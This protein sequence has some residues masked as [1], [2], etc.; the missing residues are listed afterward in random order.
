LLETVP[1]GNEQQSG[2]LKELADEIE[3]LAGQL[4]LVVRLASHSGLDGASQFARE[5]STHSL[6]LRITSWILTMRANLTPRS[7]FL[8][9]A[10]RL[11][12]CVALGDAVGRMISWQRSYWIP[13]TIAV[14]LKPDFTTTISRGVLRL[15]G[16]FLGLLVA[17]GL[18]HL[19]PQSAVTELFLVG[20]FTLLLRSLGP[21]NYGIF[22][23]AISGLIVFL[24]AETGIPP[25]TVVS[26]RAINT[27]AGGIFALVAYA[28]WPTWERTQV[29]STVADMLD[30]A[31]AYFR[32]VAERFGLSEA[33]KP[34][35]LDQ[36]RADWR[37]TRSAAEAS[38]DR[39]SSEPR[40]PPE[41]S[42][43]LTSMLASSSAFV[44]SVMGLEA[45][46]LKE[47]SHTA[48]EAFRT[49][50]H[51][52]ELTLYFLAAALRGSSGALNVLPKLRED[53][54]RMVQARDQ[55]SLEDELVLIETDRLTSALNTLREQVTRYVGG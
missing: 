44:Y 30:A 25:S 36:Y 20:I 46:I 51:D 35:E 17:T 5:E 38:V 31:R 11:C 55:L 14:V 54:T 42:R 1:Q 19:F 26:E 13:M 37:R 53:Y 45:E 29:S 47:H 48:P 16:T 24:I 18:Y 34:S 21:A 39:V 10:I 32:S 50:A 12:T 6:R 4:R 33:L 3:V 9:H 41:Q 8:R 40:T 23:V 52:V 7:A 22:S 2:L 27:A 15:A 43:C 28:L 49:F